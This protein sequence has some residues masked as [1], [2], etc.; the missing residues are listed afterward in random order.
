M[1]VAGA[2]RL[3]DGIDNLFETVG[4]HLVNRPLPYRQIHN[5]IRFLVVVGTIFQSQKIVQVHQK[6]RRGAGS[7]QHAGNHENHVYE[8][9]AVGLQVGRAGGVAADAP[10]A[11]DKPWIHGDACAIVG[12]AGLVILINEMVVQQMQVPVCKLL[13]VEF[14]YTLAQHPTVQTYKT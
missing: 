4:N 7:A 8:T 6:F 1:V 10:R 2:A 3:V 13:S 14:F 9:S 11:A 12:D 5:T